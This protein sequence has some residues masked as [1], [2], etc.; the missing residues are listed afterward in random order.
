MRN[1]FILLLALFVFV[2]GCE[3]D[4]IPDDVGGGSGTVI[5]GFDITNGGCYA[6]CQVVFTNN[7]VDATSFEWDFGDSTPISTQPNPTHTYELPGDYIVKLTAINDNGTDLET[8]TLLVKTVT[9]IMTFAGVNNDEGRSVQQTQDGGY[10]IAGGTNSQGAGS[11][12]LYL[13]KTDNTG[14]LS[15]ERTYGGADWDYGYS[16]QQTLDDGYIITGESES[17]LYLI[18]TDKFGNQNWS[19][20]Y[21]GGEGH[22]VQQTLDGGYIIAGST[23]SQGAGDY[24]IYLIKTDNDGNLVWE[25]TFGGTNEDFGYSVQQTQDGGYVIVGTTRSE[26]AGEID[27]YLIKTDNAGIMVWKKTFGG[28]NKDHGFSVQQ[29]LDGGYIIAG[30]TQIV[31]DDDVYLI[32]TN[33][34]G[35]LVWEKTYG[36]ASEG[37]SVQQTLDGGYVI[38]GSTGSEGA[39]ATDFYLIKTD[40]AGNTV[41]TKT[42]GGVDVEYGYSVKQTQDGGFIITGWTQSTGTGIS[43]VYLIKTDKDGNVE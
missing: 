43:D 26:G 36:T 18:K 27:V 17:N 13:I 9:F 4:K 42:F 2:I 39:G 35:N 29:T 34:A 25:K 10:I 38:A 30:R 11:M 37:Y 22:S 41:W 3:L 21:G 14:N 24:D 12:D 8:K 33:N 16:V 28:A 1:T 31:G 40:N 5:A 20:I 32:K 6:P 15:W 7:S 23:Y 19:R